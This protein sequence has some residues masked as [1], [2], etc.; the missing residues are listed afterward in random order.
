MAEG[1]DFTLISLDQKKKEREEDEKKNLLEAIDTFRDRV[2][3]GEHDGVVL[4]GTGAMA[5]ATAVTAGWLGN[6]SLIGLMEIV[7]LELM[8]F[9]MHHDVPMEDDDDDFD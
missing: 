4:I 8:E 6:P 5:E 1:N 2:V 3:K 7:K 9:V